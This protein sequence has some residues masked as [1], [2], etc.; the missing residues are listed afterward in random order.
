MTSWMMFEVHYIYID[1]LEHALGPH[2]E[3]MNE[4]LASVT[5]L[6][7]DKKNV[8]KVTLNNLGTK[9]SWWQLNHHVD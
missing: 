7:K 5:K 9:V 3:D 8:T 6:A 2:V 4:H 1:D